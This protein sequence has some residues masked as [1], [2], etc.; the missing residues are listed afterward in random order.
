MYSRFAALLCLTFAVFG[1][2]SASAH[3]QWTFVRGDASGDAQVDVTDA[4]T[5]LEA[6]FGGGSTACSDAL[7]V[8]DDGAIDVSDPI[9]LLS[10]LFSGDSPPPA[11]YPTCGSDPTAD[12][13][14]CVGPLDVCFAPV[15]P[16]PLYPQALAP[17]LITADFNG[18]G[19]V[20]RAG[21][22]RILL[23]NGN[24]TFREAPE[25]P[26]GV[27]LLAQA[28][29]LNGDGDLDLIGLG[30]ELNVLLGF[31][32]GT[33][34]P[35]SS[36]EVAGFPTSGMFSTIYDLTVGNVNQD[37]IPDVIIVHDETFFPGLVFRA[38]SVFI[39]VGDGTFLPAISVDSEGD[40]SVAVTSHDFDRD[41]HLDLV[42]TNVDSG[43]LSLLFG[44]GD[45]TFSPAQ[46]IDPLNAPR[47]VTIVD[48]DEDG[49][50]DLIVAGA[51]ATSFLRGNG[52]GTFEAPL[53]FGAASGFVLAADLNDDQVIDLAASGQIYLGLGSG[54]LALGQSLP[55][56]L[57]RLSYA[58]FNGDGAT[59]LATQGTILF[60][61]GDGTF[62][63]AIAYETG[64][65]S[66][67]VEVSDLNGDGS[68]DLV[69]GRSSGADGEIGVT[70][71]QGD[72][73][74]L[75]TQIFTTLS[76]AGSV[77]IAD[78]DDNGIPDIASLGQGGVGLDIH[79]GTG[80]GSFVSGLSISL[81][82][83]LY[84]AIRVGDF[85]GDGSNDLVGASILGPPGT[86]ITIWLGN[87]D[88][89]FAPPLVFGDALGLGHE[90]LTTADF[91]N[92]GQLDFAVDT[93]FEIALVYLGNGDGT[94]SAPFTL[95]GPE[96]WD[97]LTTGD[98]DGDGNVDLATAGVFSGQYSVFL[99]NGDG[100]F[101][102]PSFT[103]A[104]PPQPKMITAGDCDGDGNLDLVGTE[105]GSRD[106]VVLLGHGDGTFDSPLAF[107]TT[108]E[109]EYVRTS[110]LNND[111]KLDLVVVGNGEASVLLNQCP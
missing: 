5:G 90:G 38:M 37:S 88:G 24:G 53:P 110:D 49:E 2:V 25:Y 80:D 91:N 41:G 36:F 84:F 87:G 70:L 31:G 76:P 9:A 42:V 32:D 17:G 23:G 3:A 96:G 20:D 97:S 33:F 74:F 52:D 63:S 103:I 65:N 6:V 30:S 86:G 107:V 108:N 66:A 73:T 59:D 81:V 67:F 60:G 89:S 28:T 54:A 109:A 61:N 62:R 14:D 12:G 40:F 27:V 22:R 68:I 71:G 95:Q 92:D 99:G 39:G 111:A 18:D 75:P 19:I 94:F 104:M 93:L 102:A 83:D 16:G 106:V 56:L 43:D 7:D 44:L 100:T 46:T 105:W 45:G 35:T 72:G 34:G 10:Y 101:G 51:S 69:T 64:L 79:L 55:I 26:S 1:L 15:G 29:D 78:F 77:A 48:L 57:G 13:I 85:N 21:S 58:D 4:V 8:N 98:F 82:S 50:V 47:S 11:P